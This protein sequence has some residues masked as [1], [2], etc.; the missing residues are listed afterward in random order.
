MLVGTEVGQLEVDIERKWR[1]VNYRDR[2]LEVRVRQHG[3]IRTASLVVRVPL[4]G[5]SFHVKRAAVNL[6]G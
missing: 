2:L 4:Q 6:L 5:L 3:C 1:A